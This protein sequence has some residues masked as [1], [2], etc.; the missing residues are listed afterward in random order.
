MD[1]KFLVAV[2]TLTTVL[3]GN[4]LAQGEGDPGITP[5]SILYGLDKAYERIQL[6]LARDEASKARLHLE[7]AAERIAET[8]AM[9]DKGKPEYIPD[10]TED[11]EVSINKSQEIAEIAQRLGR[12]VTKINELV[13]LATS[14]H[15]EVLEEVYRKVPEQAKPALQRAM[16]SSIRGQEK[17]LDRLGE[18]VPERS[19]EL[20]LELAEKRLLKARERARAGEEEEVK[21][22]IEEYGR[23]VNKS[24]EMAARAERLGRN[25]TKVNE[26]IASATSVHL[27]VLREV[28][29]RVPEAAKP[30]IDMAMNVSRRGY[31]EASEALHRASIPL[32]LP[33]QER[34][35]A[36]KQTDGGEIGPPE[37]VKPP[38]NVTPPTTPA[39]EETPEKPAIPP[40]PTPKPAPAP[41]EEKPETPER[42]P[43]SGV[44]G[45]ARGR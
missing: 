7:F 36:G 12:N 5:D 16:N 35:R 26:L 3:S 21:E 4:A 13:A 42:G 44:P 32:S 1:I 14:A 40:T 43:P 20:Y 2:I 31:I 30:A 11:Y 23:K 25:V 39:K 38:V 34:A 9:V 22:L 19:A 29:E 6:I 41:Q 18:V 27:E 8:K 15:L 10:L 33:P 24:L 28:Y 37:W 17:A 45:G